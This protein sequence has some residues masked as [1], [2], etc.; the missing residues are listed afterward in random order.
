MS[1]LLDTHVVVWWKAGGE[2]LSARARRE[3]A[4]ADVLLISPLSFWEIGMLA[5]RRRLALDRNLLEW[6]ADLLEEPNIEIAPLSARAAAS[7]AELL[8]DFP[9]DPADRMIYATAREL[10]VPML[11]KDDGIRAYAA[12][13]RDVRVI[14]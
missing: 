3:I 8:P 5:S 10:L 1:V 13:E 14:W 12:D 6:I 2:R 4:R 7:A 9:G 11:S